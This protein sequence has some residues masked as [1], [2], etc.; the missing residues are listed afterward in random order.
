MRPGSFSI[1]H[2]TRIAGCLRLYTSQNHKNKGLWAGLGG[3][4]FSLSLYFSKPLFPDGSIRSSERR[5]SIGWKTKIL[6][7][8]VLLLRLKAGTGRL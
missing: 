8:G 3:S 7:G 1:I 4:G 5:A 6:N 2:R